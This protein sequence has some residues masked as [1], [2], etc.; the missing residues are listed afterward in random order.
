M[1]TI[2]QV[3][4]AWT[5]AKGLPGVST[6]YCTG[7]METFRAALHNFFNA[8]KSLY[9]SSVTI[10]IP[11]TG[12][13]INSDTGLVTGVWTS[14][15]DDAIACTGTGAYAAP[16]GMVVN[17][18]TGIYVG[19]RELRGKTFLVPMITTTFQSDGSLNDTDRAGVETDANTLADTTASMVI[20]SRST[21]TIASVASAS[22]PDL[23]AVLRSRRT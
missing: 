7:T 17:W 14:G 9:P 11:S 6:F 4:V 5:G 23:V 8:D 3:R 19:G 18:H 16:A 21:N 22:V 13:D 1:T 12:S 20:Y 2:H 10:T 15:T